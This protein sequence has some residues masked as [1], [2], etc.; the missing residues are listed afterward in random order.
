MAF[1]PS[2]A[3]TKGAE[4]VSKRISRVAVAVVLTSVSVTLHSRGAAPST[5]QPGARF[6]SK[7]AAHRGEREPAGADRSALTRALERMPLYFIKNQGQLDSRVA[8]YVQGRDAALYFTLDGVT[9]AL[10]NPENGARRSEGRFEKASLRREKTRGPERFGRWTVKLDFVG[11]NPH[12]T[13]VAAD[14]TPA[15]VSY[16]K[17]PKETWKAGLATYGSIL[18]SDLWPGIDLIYSGTASRLKYS[19]LVKPGADPARV[20]LAYR[21]VKGIRRNEA[22]QL[23][24]ETDAGRFQDDEPYAYQEVDGRRQGIGVSY[25][26]DRASTGGSHAYGFALAPYDRSKPLVLDPATSVYTGYIGG[27]SDDR[28]YAIAV[29]GSG[30]AYI[31]GLT[32]SS[33]AT[34]PVTTGPDLTYN[35]F[36]DAFVAKVNAAGTA[37]VYCGYIGGND[38]DQGNAIAVDGSGNAYVTGTTFSTEASFPVTVGPDLTQNGSSDAFVAK[39]NAAGTALVYCGYIGGT[40]DDQG[41]AIAV[42]GSG[43]AYVTGTTFST[44]ASFPVTVGPDLTQNGAS[45]AFVAKVNAAGTALVYCGYIGGSSDD[46]GYGIAVDGSGNAYVAGFTYSTEATF[47]VTVGP[48][49][50]QNGASDAFVAKVNAA[51]TALVYCGYI[52]G[53]GNDQAY[54]I[55]V[56]GSGNA[57]VTGFT[58]SSQATFPVTVGP[59]LT[60]NGGQDAFVAKVNAAGTALVYCGYIGG[61]SDDGGNAI[62]VDGSGNAYVAGFAN[63]GQATFPVNIGPNLIYNGGGDAFVAKVNASGIGLAYCGYIGGNGLDTALGIALDSSGNAYVT[64]YTTSTQATFPVTVG[65]D[66]T[67]NGGAADAFV[68]KITD[69]CAGRPKGDINSDG[70]VNTAD[71]FYLINFIFAGGPAPLC[72][73]DVNGDL[74]TNS[75]DVFYLINNLFAGGPAPR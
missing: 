42:D 70:V 3:R 31:T 24:V 65:P 7:T 19:F 67:Y 46:G 4:T 71:L 57:Y 51:G 50:T 36:S 62:A 12:P 72:S 58:I 35:L 43:N 23:E 68:T 10:T 55:A 37:L 27:N 75:A 15:V 63:S 41:N 2:R 60:Y 69:T 54:G 14:P 49:V 40:G 21:G 73:A 32:F 64:G 16:F 20:Q 17:G 11:A 30:N 29:D 52:G 33:E 5:L 6:S 8:Y 1:S 66:L 9:L 56:D 38:D 13:I 44:E 26:L 28:G 22:G 74:Q 39:V 59:G 45:D 48:D 18:Y 34:F 61:S 47:P 25:A 53:S